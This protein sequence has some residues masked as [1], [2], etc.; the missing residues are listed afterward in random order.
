MS[1]SDTAPAPTRREWAALA[2]LSIGL[3]LIV[4]DGT[5]VG[6]ALPDIIAD[7]EHARRNSALTTT[8]SMGQEVIS[9]YISELRAHRTVLSG[10][11][12]SLKLPDSPAGAAQKRAKT[13]EQARS[14]AR[15]RWGTGQGA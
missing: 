1:I 3:G 6:V 11:L 9:P 5:I 14:A 2:V 7:L 15:A 8:G 13:S 4:L 12:K 10:L